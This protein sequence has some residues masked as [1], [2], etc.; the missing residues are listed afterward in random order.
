MA[1]KKKGKKAK[2]P[3]KPDKTMQLSDEEQAAQAEATRLA[4]RKADADAAAAAAAA[5]QKALDALPKNALQTALQDG[6]VHKIVRG[7]ALRAHEAHHSK[8]KKFRVHP[9]SHFSI[10]NV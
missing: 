5:A 1:K 4:A 3:P 9:T 7:H 2:S 8:K 10:N 6:R